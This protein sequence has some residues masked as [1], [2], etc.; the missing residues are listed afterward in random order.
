MA[1]IYYFTSTGN[2]LYMAKKIGQAIQAECVP[3]Q[4]A[5]ATCGEDV[6]GIVYPVFFWGLP[7]TVE[8][9][10]EKLEIT[11]QNPYIFAVASYGDKFI[12][13]NG[14]VE[15][16]LQKK[17]HHCSYAGKVK[18]VE[19]YLPMYELKDQ[20]QIHEKSEAQIAAVIQDIKAGKKNSPGKY[21]KMNELIMSRYPA[22]KSGDCDGQFTIE[23]C[24]GCG[25]CEKMCIRKNI[26]IVDGKPV[27]GGNCELCLSCL[28]A[29]PQKAINWEHTKGKGHYRNPN[30]TMKELMDSKQ[31]ISTNG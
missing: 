20:P 10:L 7:K 17:G 12:G 26:K 6:I 11:A 16:L 14:R 24:T 3:M 29:C 31:K 28:H 13:A 18:S 8:E 4:S 21:T 23:G 30:I 5:S 22:L 19:N 25:I 15:Q 1:V 9:F 2:C 27:F